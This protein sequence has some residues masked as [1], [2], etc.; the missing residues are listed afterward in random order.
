MRCR[1]KVRGK[2]DDLSNQDIHLSSVN[3]FQT[4]CIVNDW[5][6]QLTSPS[7]YLTQVTRVSSVWFDRGSSEGCFHVSFKR[8]EYSIQIYKIINYFI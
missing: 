4:R 3:T 8:F 6:S 2:R 1:D 5:E 7:H